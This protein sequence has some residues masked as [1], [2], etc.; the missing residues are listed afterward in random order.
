MGRSKNTYFIDPN[1]EMELARL[2][3][4]DNLFNELIDVFPGQFQAAHRSDASILDL[5]CG[6]GGWLLQVAA[7]HPDYSTIGVDISERMIRYARAQA[8]VRELSTQFRIMDILTFPWNFPDSSFDLVNIRF[9]TGFVP[10]SQWPR[11]LQESWRVLR[12]GGV[13]RHIEVVHMST[14]MSP[15]MHQLAHMVYRGMH[16]AGLSFGPYEGATGAIL[17]A[18]LKQI[19]FEE[20]ALTPYVADL[21]SGAP[22]H[23]PMLENFHVSNRLLKPFLLKMKICTSEEFDE[24][25]DAQEREYQGQDFSAHWYINSLSCTKPQIA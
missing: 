5:A 8:E 6:P 22:L 1:S 21:S 18:H 25:L 12:S 15:A 20:V 7:A 3:L 14:P 16:M 10:V 2:Q 23:A 4:Q 19:G 17:A 13:F 9:S 24:L 11:L